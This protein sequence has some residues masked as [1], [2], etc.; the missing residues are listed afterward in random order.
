MILAHPIKW[1]S[2]LF[3]KLTLT[4]D[5]YQEM[6]KLFPDIESFKTEMEELERWLYANESKRPKSHWKAQVSNW[7]RKANRIAREK[8]QQRLVRG[9]ERPMSHQEASKSL[10]EILAHKTFPS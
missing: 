10:A 1:Q 6:R 4:E 2:Q 3:P 9:K 8:R 7:M 5:H